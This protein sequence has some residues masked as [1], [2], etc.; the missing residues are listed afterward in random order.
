M[1]VRSAH[2]EPGFGVSEP[3]RRGGGSALPAQRMGA[4]HTLICEPP[5]PHRP[6]R[7]ASRLA[8][9]PMV[10][11]YHGNVLVQHRKRWFLKGVGVL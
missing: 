1:P 11:C 5:G 7:E 8:G 10:P 2:L 3:V 9:P 4:A 6:I